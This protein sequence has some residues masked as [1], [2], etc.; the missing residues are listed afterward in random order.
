MVVAEEVRWFGYVLFLG[1]I[2]DR[3]ALK[4]V[5]VYWVL[6]EARQD[7]PSTLAP[8]VES[9]WAMTAV[10]YCLGKYIMNGEGART[11]IP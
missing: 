9:M 5:P 4:V 2:I 3:N 10:K 11:H 7:S 8:R 6:I 1:A